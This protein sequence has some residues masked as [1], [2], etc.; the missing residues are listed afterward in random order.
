MSRKRITA[1]G[2]SAILELPQEI[3]DELGVAVGD[4]LDFSV[5]DGTLVER[6]LGAS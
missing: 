1:D 5:V 4:E 6:C 2:N 3:L